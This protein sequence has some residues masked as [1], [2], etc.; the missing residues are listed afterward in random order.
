MPCFFTASVQAITKPG[1]QK[2]HCRASSAT[3]AFWTA[4][5]ASGLPSPSTVVMVRPSASTPSIM[6]A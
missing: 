3:N 5:I 1:V 2:P 6:Q 4:L